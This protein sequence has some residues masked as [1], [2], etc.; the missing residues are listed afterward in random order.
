MKTNIIELEKVLSEEIETY[1]NLEKIIIAK[2]ESLVKG[3]MEKLKNIDCEIEKFVSITQELD[4]KRISVSSKFSDEN[5]TLEEIIEII[6]KEDQKEA[7][8]IAN[9]RKQLKFK[10]E[11]VQRQNKIN[12]QLIENALK[13]I[14]FSIN[15][16]IKAVTPE[17]VSYNN[18]GKFKNNNRNKI[19]VSS[20]IHDI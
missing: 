19:S 6:E 5:L 10:A 7:Q 11:N 3:D 16:I 2:K 14:E 8:Q 9:L 15:S 20:V 4:N 13:L 1:T 12:A 17:A 18:M